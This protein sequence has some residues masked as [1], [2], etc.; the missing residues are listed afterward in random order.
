MKNIILSTRFAGM[1][2]RVLVT[3]TLMMLLSYVAWA[4]PPSINAHP[5]NRSVCLGANTTFPII[6]F[7]ATSYQWQENDGNGWV[8]VANGGVYSGATTPVLTLTGVTAGMSG[9]EYRCIATGPDNPPATSNSASLTVNALTAITLQP[10]ANQTIC[11]GGN[12][13]LTTAATGTGIAYQWYRYNGA[14]YDAVTNNAVYSGA[15]SATLTIT[16][17][18]NAGTSA[19]TEDYYCLITGTCGNAST[20]H[21]YLTVNAAP[22]IVTNPADIT[23][24]EGYG[25]TFEVIAGGTAKTYQ[26]QISYTNGVSWINLANNATFS[27]VTSSEMQ[28][29]ATDLTMQQALFRC[30]VSG[31]CT[32]TATSAGGRLTVTPTHKF[33]TQPTHASV[34][35]GGNR[36]FAVT[37]TGQTLTYQWQ[38]N[39]GNGW[40]NLANGGV[41]SGVTTNILLLSGVTPAMNGLSYRCIIGSQCPGSLASNAASLTVHTTLTLT[42][43]PVANQTICSGGNAS[44]TTAATGTGVTYQWYRYNG[45]TYDALTNSGVYSGATSATLTITGITNAGTSAVVEDYYCSIT[46]TCGSAST[47]HSYLTINALPSVLTNPMNVT[48]CEGYG[49]SFEITAGGTGITYQWQV[50]Y[51]NGMSWAN[52]VNNATFTHVTESEMQIVATDLG[53]QQAMFRCMVS[54]T[55]TPPAVSASGRLTVDPTQKFVTHPTHATACPGSNR[56]FAVTATGLNLAYQWQENDGNGWVNLANGGV[57]SG[58]NTNILLLTGVTPA[59]DILEYRCVL[60]G[61]CP[62]SVASNPASLTV[63]VTTAITQQPAASQT[64]CSGGNASITTAAVGTALTYQWYRYNGVTYDAIVNNAVYSGATS[65]MLTITGITNNGPSAQVQDYYCAISGQ[66]GSA[67]TQHSYLT[68]NAL[69]AVTVQPVNDITCVNF[70]ASFKITATGTALTYQW[71]SSSNNG[72]SWTNLVNDATFSGVTTSELLIDPTTTA[73]NNYQFRCRVSGV[74]APMATSAPAT[75]TID[76]NPAITMHPANTSVCAGAN[77]SF[78]VGA[79]GTDLTYQW[80]VNSGMGWTNIANGGIYSN[81]T[82]ATL[83]LTGP[84]TMHNNNQYRVVVSGKCIPLVVSNHASLT[85]HTAPSITMQPSSVAVCPGGNTS[86]TVTATGTA[87]AYQWEANSGLGWNN[88]ADGGV[89][90]G[91]NSATLNVTG[92]GMTENGTMYRCTISG[93]CT[94]PVTSNTATLTLNIVPSIVTHPVN[95]TICLNGNTS[96]TVAAAGTGLTYQWQVS[97]DGI[98]WSPVINSGAHSGATTSTLNITS[99]GLPMTGNKYRCVVSGTCTPHVVTNVVTLTVNIPTAINGQPSGVVVCP[100]ANVLFAVSATGSGVTYQW[101]ENTGSTWVDITNGGMYSGATTNK[102]A[103]SSVQT[104]HN[105]YQYRCVVSG[106]CAPSPVTSSAVTLTVNTITV[107]TAQPDSML[108]LCSG[109]DTSF[110]VVATGTNLSYQWYRYNGTTYVPLTNSG[111][112]SGTTT[113]SLHIDNITNTGAAAQTHLYYCSIT[114]ACGSASTIQSKLIVNAL[115]MVTANPVHDTTCATF[116]ASFKINATGTGISYQWQVSYNQG[117]SWINLVNDT[118]FKRVTENEMEIVSA[119]DSLDSTMYRCVVTGACTPMATS[120]AAMLTVNPLLMPAVTIQPDN[121]NICAGTLI[122]FTATPVNGGTSPSYQW[123]VNGVNAGSN[124]SV[125][126]STTLNNNDVVTCVLTSNAT[127]AQPQTVVSNAVTMYVT[128]YQLPV[129][130]V[131]SS[132]GNAACSGVPVTFSVATQFG[133]AMPSY[134][135]QVNG[136]NVGTD[137]TVYVTDS[138][139]DTDVV[140]CILTSSFMCP[141]QQIVSSNNIQMNITQTT[142]ATITISTVQDTT[143]CLGATVKLSA[144]YNNSGLNPQFQWM[145]NGNNIP[146]ET[147]N[148]FTST[149]IYNND[150]IQCRF[151]SSAQCVFPV[152]SDSLRF[153]VDNPLTPQVKVNMS[154][155]GGDSYTFMA[156]PINGGTNPTYEWFVNS[157]KVAGTV[158]NTYTT[159]LLKKTDDVYVVMT[160]NYPCV[161][162]AKA[163]SRIINLNVGEQTSK[164]NDLKLFPNPNNGKF[165]ITGSYDVVGEA[166]ANITIT[167]AVGQVIYKSAANI[168]GGKLN[169]TI[170]MASSPASGLYIMRLE[171]DG[172]HDVLRF[173]IIE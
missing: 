42:M 51:N 92:A 94:P 10:V 67:S 28:V 64:I 14:T 159:S 81:A 100:S 18:T 70:S 119:A 102:L 25:A 108:T 124:S 12:A 79:T 87:L 120:A 17:I 82:T 156:T 61:K 162:T 173:Q 126:V 157:S 114:G 7:N 45:T 98:A 125:F 90:S 65:A 85:I 72:V 56:Q 138:L 116:G 148:T 154:Y 130:T 47:Q 158:G 128:A 24:C 22:S 141:S 131:T 142:I 37:A 172:K 36:Q 41:Y 13:V 167:N 109:G 117:N 84:A 19:V 152:V 91:T 49:A 89:Y 54:G 16:G 53:M 112:Y 77:T 168:A 163:T 71:Q 113:A 30:V 99:A 75:L 74:C 115:P 145:K 66:C 135:W 107:I 23:V 110:T 78:S 86:F 76:T 147:Q 3:M 20:Q 149:T 73:M 27:N 169:H 153:T 83:N 62:G 55:C 170:N 5:V 4:I 146:G 39:D 166:T 60:T 118:V 1:N 34:C 35:P 52:L 93:L 105:G 80:Q 9:Y 21:S 6:A 88:L 165:T 104:M 58:V 26:W 160:S 127:C 29:I 121:N 59:M 150:I 123:K 155:N 144:Y 139:Q 32:P 161:T 43:Q 50:S 63:P 111:F 137:T 140:R 46:G 171:I 133:G 68:V 40:I 164:L 151:I 143:T 33:V 69:P 11:T 8:N 15:A 57:Y 95:S 132:S 31:A 44:M 136:V 38:E 129:A 101:Q 134:Q 2:Y 106:L 122:T 97:S 103:L 48:V 96:F